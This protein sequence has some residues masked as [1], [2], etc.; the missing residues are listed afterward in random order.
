MSAELLIIAKLKLSF[1]PNMYDISP[2]NFVLKQTSYFTLDQ[3]IYATI[4]ATPLGDLLSKAFDAL[5][6]KIKKPAAEQS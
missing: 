2:L 6:S 3:A 5:F 1:L 4:K